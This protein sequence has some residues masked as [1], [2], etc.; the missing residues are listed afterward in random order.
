MSD[1][2]LVILPGWGHDRTGW[3]GFAAAVRPLMR[4]EIV[5][6]PGFGKQPLVSGDWGV[7]EYAAWVK[8]YIEEGKL[9]QVVL[10]GHSFG[11]RI[12]SVLASERPPWLSALILYGAPCLYRPS[13]AVRLKRF[14]AKVARAFGIR[15]SAT[16]DLA[17]AK[18]HGLDTVFRKVVP[19]DQ[20]ERLPEIAV[21]TLLLWGERDEDAPVRLAREMEA[22]IPGSELTVLPKA[23]HSVH[24]ENAALFYGTVTRFIQAHP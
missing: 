24:L 11:G 9:T 18:A 17:W 13:L 16:A 5:E 6:L 2:T 15:R 3:E 22:L 1:R 19:F 23:G 14:L 10:L 21:P 20:T 12:A 7:P 8:A 4:V